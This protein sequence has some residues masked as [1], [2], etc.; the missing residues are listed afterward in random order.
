VS[1]ARPRNL[2][3]TLTRT[4]T[5]TRTR[6]DPSPDPSPS[7]SPSPNLSPNLAPDPTQGGA[8][9]LAQALERDPLCLRARGGD[10]RRR[11]APRRDA[12]HAGRGEPAATRPPRAVASP[13][14]RTPAR[15]PPPSHPRPRT[16]ARAPL[17][18]RPHLTAASPPRLLTLGELQHSAARLRAA[19]GHAERRRRPQG[20][21]AAAI[22]QP[23]THA[24]ATLASRSL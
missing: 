18:A 5:L 16:P 9:A 22:P 19:L 6:T 20:E 11:A 15:A 14:P 2:A 1:L 12:A 13:A 10:G 8:T 24:A 7:P 23:P 4:L 17:S 3:R 21:R